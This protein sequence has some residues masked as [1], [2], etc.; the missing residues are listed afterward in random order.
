MAECGSGK[1]CY[2]TKGAAHEA[3][4][5]QYF[6]SDVYRCGYCNEWHLAGHRSKA[7]SQRRMG[8]LDAYARGRRNTG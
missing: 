2:P 5:H 1:I 8:A 3:R 6:R 4:R 7:R